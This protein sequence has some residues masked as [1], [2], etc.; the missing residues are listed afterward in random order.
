[1]AKAQLELLTARSDRN[2]ER[3]RSDDS[4]VDRLDEMLSRYLGPVIVGALADPDVTDIYVNPQDQAIRFDT[5]SRGKIDSG[6]SIDAH[7]VEMFLNAV[8]T[9]LSVTLTSDTPRLEAELPL[10]TFGGSRL[11]GF[12]PPVA[13]GP[14]FNIRKPSAAIYAPHDYL[15]TLERPELLDQDFVRDRR[16]QLIEL[17]EAARTFSQQR[18]NV[19]SPFPLQ[20]RDRQITRCGWWPPSVPFHCPAHVKA[21]DR[22]AVHRDNRVQLGYLRPVS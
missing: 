15:R 12:I 3:T 9:R 16:Y 17:R 6:Q 20:N 18:E 22:T 21:F 11:Q 1:M 19:W 13:L 4:K 5:R 8:A 7:R 2:T 14:A 10:E